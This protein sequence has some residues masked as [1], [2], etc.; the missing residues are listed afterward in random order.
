[1]ADESE[2]LTRAPESAE[3]ELGPLP[4][5]FRISRYIVEETLGKG[6]FGITYR[7]RDTQLGRAV[8]IKEYMPVHLAARRGDWVVMPRST[9]T[10]EE[11]VQGSARFL[12]E[13]RTLAQLEGVAGVVNV[14]D[15]LAANGTA[16]LVMEF[17]RGE[18]LDRLLARV[19]TLDE[20]ELQRLLDP[21]LDGLERVHA[22]GFLHRD[23]KPSNILIDETGKPKLIDFGAARESASGRTGQMTAIHTP[24]YAPLEQLT[25]SRQGPWTDIYALAAT[26]HHCIGGKPPPDVLERMVEDQLVPAVEVGRGR[27]DKAF[28]AAVDA[29]LAIKVESRPH[30]IADWTAIRRGDARPAPSPAPLPAPRPP[31][32]RKLWVIGG[33]GAVAIGIV[34]VAAWLAMAPPAGP[35]A[36]DGAIA[37]RE[38]DMAEEKARQEAVARERSEAEAKARREADERAR[39]EAAV[40][41]RA[42]A[43]AKARREADEKARQEAVVRERAEAEAKARREADETARQEAADQTRQDAEAIEKTLRLTEA[44]RRRVQAALTIRGFDTGSSDGVFGPRTRQMIAAYQRSRNEPQTGYLTADQYSQLIRETEEA[45]ARQEEDRRREAAEKTMPAQPAKPPAPAKPS[46]AAKPTESASAAGPPR[47]RDP[48]P[49]GSFDGQYTK[50]LSSTCSAFRGWTFEGIT[51]VNNLFDMTWDTTAGRSFRCQVK[52]ESDGVFRNDECRLKPSGRVSGDKLT[53]T[54]LAGG[55][56]WCSASAQR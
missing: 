46:E 42:E 3:D 36:R 24:G 25:S 2:N 51:V 16:Y 28:L 52:I 21:L 20:Q 27:Y 11:F 19:G 35:P 6:G 32:R 9:R 43:E 7:A 1:M 38:R 31:A 13:A 23:I 15:F 45:Y 34:A 41:E 17:V 44:Q 56:L 26:L 4:A 54:F 5:G 29:G 8:A 33:A 14:F 50:N 18:T 55:V 37:N 12:A 48:L 53:M 22:A 39:Q 10:A 30:S 40:R 47:K 49:L